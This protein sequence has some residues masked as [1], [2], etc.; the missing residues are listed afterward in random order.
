MSGAIA[1]DVSDGGHE[2]HDNYRE[3]AIANGVS[4]DDPSLAECRD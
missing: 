2:L 4:P 3:M 1:D